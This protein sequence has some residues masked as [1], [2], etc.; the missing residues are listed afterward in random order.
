LLPGQ[1]VGEALRRVSVGAAASNQQLGQASDHQA[2]ESV[3]GSGED[4]A[5]PQ[6]PS[7]ALQP[8]KAEGPV[9]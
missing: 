4:A 3:Y 6:E 2:K 9:P 5:L 1:V 8:G 7:Q